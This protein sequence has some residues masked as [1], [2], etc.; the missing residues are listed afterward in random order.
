MGSSTWV[1]RWDGD[2]AEA[3]LPIQELLTKL[4]ITGSPPI[5]RD[6]AAGVS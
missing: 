6:G 1:I 5:A 4:P 3:N 2:R